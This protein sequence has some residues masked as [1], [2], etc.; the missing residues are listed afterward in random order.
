[1]VEVGWDDHVIVLVHKDIGQLA[2]H[3]Q[4]HGGDEDRKNV[5]EQDLAEDNAH[6]QALFFS[7]IEQL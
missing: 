6:N 4:Q 5:A 1:M 3:Q 2:D 7:C